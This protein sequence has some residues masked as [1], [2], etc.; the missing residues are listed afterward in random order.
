MMTYPSKELEQYT[1]ADLDPGM[2]EKLTHLENELQ[3]I[4]QEEIIL[5]AYKEK[6][7][8]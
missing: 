2:L 7:K 8:T 4:S 1:A 3:T 6:E 5:I